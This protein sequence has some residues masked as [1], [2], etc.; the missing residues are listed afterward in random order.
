[1]LRVGHWPAVQRIYAEGI[2][3]GDAT[4]ETEP[5]ANFELFVAGHL[6]EHMIVAHDAGVVLGWAALSSISDRCAYRGVA[7]NSVYVAAKARGRGVGRALLT[8]LVWRAEEAGIWTVQSG[9]FPTNV[10]SLALHHACGFRTVGTRERLGQLEG[11]WRSVVL[12]ERRSER[13]G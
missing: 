4:F 12:V 3:T 5:P 2:A 9:I 13:I 1:M 7:E 11:V 8:Q 10:A 6:A